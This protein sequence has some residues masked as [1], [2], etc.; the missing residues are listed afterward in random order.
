MWGLLCTSLLSER[1]TPHQRLNK[2]THREVFLLRRVHDEERHK[3]NTWD[4][5]PAGKFHNGPEFAN[6]FE[7]RD[8]IA[9]REEDF[10]RGLTEHLIGYGLGR[11]FSK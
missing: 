9:D 10:A 8:L 4:I 11:P 3:K 1:L 6:Y 5:D 7:M 2:R